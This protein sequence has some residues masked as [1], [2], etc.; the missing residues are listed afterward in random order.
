MP[1][2]CINEAAKSPT[3][4]IAIA[5]NK[6]NVFAYFVNKLAD[7]NYY[8]DKRDYYKRCCNKHGLGYVTE[9][10]FNVKSETVLKI[11]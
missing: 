3:V 1:A 9:Q 11:Y 6:K 4:N 7:K 10:I 2:V 8:G 5:T